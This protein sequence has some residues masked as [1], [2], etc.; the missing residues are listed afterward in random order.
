MQKNRLLNTNN[1]YVLRWQSKLFHLDVILIFFF[2]SFR[3]FSHYF[4]KAI[5][6]LVHVEY[7]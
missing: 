1:L 7:L 2:P 6:L 3:L 4:T 5:K